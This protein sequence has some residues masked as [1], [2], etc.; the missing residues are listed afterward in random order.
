[1]EK[2]RNCEINMADLSSFLKAREGEEVSRGR[3]GRK[4]DSKEDTTNPL[5]YFRDNPEK[6]YYRYYYYTFTIIRAIIT[7]KHIIKLLTKEFVIFSFFYPFCPQRTVS[8]D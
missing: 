8:R 7:F 4:P 3:M 6:C 1:M 5:F 2:K